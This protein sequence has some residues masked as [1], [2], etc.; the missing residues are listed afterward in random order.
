M[1]RRRRSPSHDRDHPASIATDG[2][3][4]KGKAARRLSA[5]REAGGQDLG[6][7]SKAS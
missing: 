1:V 3:A 7:G 4:G 6:G 5:D 2:D